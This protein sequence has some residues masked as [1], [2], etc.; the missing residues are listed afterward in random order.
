MTLR[1]ST[2]LFIANSVRWISATPSTDTI[3]RS[4]RFL[5]QGAPQNGKRDL[6]G[7]YANPLNRMKAKNCTRCRFA[8]HSER[9]PGISVFSAPANR[10]SM[11]D[12]HP[13]VTGC[14]Q[15]RL[16]LQ[17]PLTDHD[18]DCI[19]VPKN[20]AAS[21]FQSQ[22]QCNARF[23]IGAAVTDEYLFAGLDFV[24]RHVEKFYIPV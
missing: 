18:T 21:L 24:M 15:A 19:F 10:Y 14:G 3:Q 12:D 23:V 16:Q 6:H 11:G 20:T 13:V 5:S 22:T 7:Q 4:I 8:A 1:L 17:H 2:L 9:L